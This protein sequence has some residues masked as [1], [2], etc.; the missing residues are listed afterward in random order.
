LTSK[1]P[2]NITI[3][4][5]NISRRYARN[6]VRIA[7]G[8][9]DR[10]KKA[11]WFPQNFCPIPLANCSWINGNHRKPFLAFGPSCSAQILCEAFG[12]TAAGFSQRHA[13]PSGA[14][15]VSCLAWWLH[16]QRCNHSQPR[17]SRSCVENRK[18]TFLYLSHIWYKIT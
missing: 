11:I 10:L 16:V 17:H 3:S 8:G 7:C 12:W 14:K 15:L 5:I 1:L 9:G 4:V 6:N 2:S 18:P 13:F